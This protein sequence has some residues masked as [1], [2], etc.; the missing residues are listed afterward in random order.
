MADGEAAH[1]LPLNDRAS[2]HGGTSRHGVIN[3][4]DKG[5]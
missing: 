3:F 1:A 2:R 5:E 4:A